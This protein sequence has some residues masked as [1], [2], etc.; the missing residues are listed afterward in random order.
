MYIVQRCCVR[1]T[2]SIFF[3]ICAMSARTSSSSMISTSRMGSTVPSTWMMLSSSKHRTTC[4]M[5]SVW[6]MLARN[7]FP[8]PAPSDAPFTM[9][10]MST[11]S[12]CEV[13]CK[14][15]VMCLMENWRKLTMAGTTLTDLL[16]TPSLSSLESGTCTKPTFGSAVGVTEYPGGKL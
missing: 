11:N 6:R 1:L 4:T 5:A 13:S 8:S 3:S 15:I 2:L 12:I 9:P 10:A 14:S 7:L 16:M